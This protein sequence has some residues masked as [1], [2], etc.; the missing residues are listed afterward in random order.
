VSRS[1]RDT[2]DHAYG[3]QDVLANAIVGA[4]VAT[5]RPPTLRLITAE[6]PVPPPEYRCA[7]CGREHAQGP[8]PLRGPTFEDLRRAGLIYGSW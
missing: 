1:G 6:A 3:E 5:A 7:N 8:C 2:T 4:L